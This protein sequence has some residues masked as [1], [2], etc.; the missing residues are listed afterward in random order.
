MKL[1]KMASVL[2][3]IATVFCVSASALAANSPQSLNAESAQASKVAA[4]E[5]IAY[6]DINAASPALKAEILEARNVIIFNETW[7]ADGYEA[8]M[9]EPDGTV[10]SVPHF[11]ELFPSDWDLPIEEPSNLN[12]AAAT[13]GNQGGDTLRVQ[14]KNPSSSVMSAPFAVAYNYEESF[15]VHVDDL[16][17][18]ETCNIGFKNE[19]TG[20][21][22]G[23]FTR[24]PVGFMVGIDAVP[25]TS[26]IVSA[27]ASTYSTPGYGTFTYAYW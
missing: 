23:V 9:T 1:Q 12:M 24:K 3:A 27:R 4:A 17:I 7:I 15:T 14:L 6:M 19:E 18:S 10:Y 13:R 22:V 8:T 5:K 11:S 25:G 26:A 20:E 2:L 16:E 21:S